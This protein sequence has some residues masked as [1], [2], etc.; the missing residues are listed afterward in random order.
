MLARPQAGTEMCIASSLDTA[1]SCFASKQLSAF[2]NLYSV[3]CCCH[4][5]R[6]TQRIGSGLDC[7][8]KT[9]CAHTDQMAVFVPDLVDQK[10]V[11]VHD[12]TDPVGQ[13]VVFV[14]DLIDQKAVFL[15]FCLI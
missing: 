10:A 7:R 5:H 1:T 6:T 8:T 13:K 14:P 15:Y 2:C 12:L 4:V 3:V 11:F 9:A